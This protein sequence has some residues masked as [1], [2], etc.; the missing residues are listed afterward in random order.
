MEKAGKEM[1]EK[2]NIYKQ[3]SNVAFASA[4]QPTMTGCH[5]SLSKEH[6]PRTA[7]KHLRPSEAKYTCFVWRPVH[8]I[9]MFQG[10]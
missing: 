9:Q 5:K 10:P 8:H 3:R 7:G 4:A 6:I 1:K 2:R